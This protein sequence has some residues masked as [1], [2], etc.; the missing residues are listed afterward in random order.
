MALVQMLK[1]VEN[2]RT[3]NN[4]IFM[5]EKLKNHLNPDLDLCTKMFSQN[6]ST[7]QYNDAKG[8]EKKISNRS[9]ELWVCIFNIFLIL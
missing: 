1:F 8:N 4:L 3:F 6:L 5:K 2:K 7:F 9:L